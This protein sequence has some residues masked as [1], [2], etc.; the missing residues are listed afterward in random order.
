VDFDA[1]LD[2]NLVAL[3]PRL[4]LLRRPV[5]HTYLWRDDDGLTLVDTSVPGTGQL[6]AAAV[7]RVGGE[8][9]RIVLTHF[10]VDHAGAA[11]EVLEWANP[12]VC[13]HRWDMPIIRGEVSGP[14]PLLRDWERPLFAQ[15][16]GDGPVHA[17]VPVRVD[18]ELDDGE[19][20]DIGAGARVVGAPGH[21]EGT[22]VLHLPA[23][24]ILFSGDAIERTPD[25]RT[26]APVFNLDS[27][28]AAESVRALAKLDFD[29]LCPA[30]G[31]PL[32]EQ[33]DA[34]VRAVAAGLTPE[35][36]GPPPV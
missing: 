23:E 6:I 12:E 25:G 20:L 35:T 5:G 19:I 17:P 3:T 9:R 13:A 24:R 21:T 2:A 8:V 10:H 1:E 14:R 36:V 4:Y 34:V 28:R 7:R 27:A 18:R 11:P 30:H 31:E 29:M 15:V 26:I 22:I 33:A 16:A 32:T